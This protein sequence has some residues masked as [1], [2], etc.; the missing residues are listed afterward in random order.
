MSGRGAEDLAIGPREHNLAH[1]FLRAPAVAHKPRGQI[2][3]QLG[4]R[5]ALARATQIAQRR[6]DALREQALPDAIDMHARGQGF[7]ALTSQSA[8]AVRRPDDV[9]VGVILGCV[10][11]GVMAAGNAGCTSSPIRS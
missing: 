6:D 9:A 10:Y 4:M 11:F 7:S 8:S 1:Q 2:I 5:R 3:E